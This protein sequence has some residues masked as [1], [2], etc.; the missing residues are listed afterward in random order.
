VTSSDIF[1]GISSL[2]QFVM[3]TAVSVGVWIAYRQLE[4]WRRERQTIRKSEVAEEMIFIVSNIEDAFKNI[5]NPFDR[6]PVDKADDKKFVY[7]RRY[8][9]I[10]DA[11][12]LFQ[13][14]REFQIR[15]DAV[16]GSEV[17]KPHVTALFNA[18][19]EVALA[20]EKLFG[21]SEDSN[22]AAAEELRK[23]RRVLYGT[24][25]DKDELGMKITGLIEA[26]KSELS[27]YAQL[28]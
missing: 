18:R 8:Q 14:L 25:T 6:I 24:W 16:I 3:A 17:T 9:R 11:N 19:T 1:E 21:L 15:C 12:E 13:R 26:I 20:I 22:D 27:D 7:K 5:R 10:T 28:S 23:S 2:A 4:S